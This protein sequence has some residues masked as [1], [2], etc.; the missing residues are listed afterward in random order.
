MAGLLPQYNLRFV[1]RNTFLE[2]ACDQELEGN[3][4]SLRSRAFSECC[5]RSSF[6]DKA[7]F[8]TNTKIGIGPSSSCSTIASDS[9]LEDSEVSEVD[10]DSTAEVDTTANTTVMLRNL[11]KFLTQTILLEVLEGHGFSSLYDF[12]YLPVD[13]QKMVN[14]GYA[15]V[16]FV[17]N[18]A[19]E[20]AMQKFDG[21]TEWP[22]AGRKA[23]ITVWNIPCQGLASQI[24][25]YRD[26]PL[27]H[28]EVAEEFRPMLFSCGI[29]QDFP[30]PT[31]QLKAPQRLAPKDAPRAKKQARSARTPRAA[32]A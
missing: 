16:N 7:G 18:E 29:K 32:K 28:P 21:F 11:P 15:I 17:T 19:A 22:V 26:S 25:K 5:V 2:V 1:V 27:M 3:N 8:Q 6:E 13:F 10:H 14:F 12:A 30:P 24:E 23:C 9:F 4:L 20:N 31:K